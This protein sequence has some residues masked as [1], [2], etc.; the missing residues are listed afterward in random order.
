MEY[1]S[2]VLTNTVEPFVFD[3][4]TGSAD[5]TCR[6]YFVMEHKG[7]SYYAIDL[8]K[9]DIKK[10]EKIIKSCEECE[11]DTWQAQEDFFD[12][13]K[14]SEILMYIE[15]DG[16]VVGFN[17]VSLLFYGEYCI[18]SI[19]EAMVRKKYQGKNLARNV[20]ILTIRWFLANSSKAKQVKKIC[21]LSISANPKVV[22]NYYKNKYITNVFDNSFNASQGLAN[23]L[24]EYMK[25]NS[26]SLVHEDY[27]FCIKNLFPGSN[28]FD[29]GD[30][31]FQ[32]CDEVKKR[33]PAD[34]D[35]IDRGDAFAWLVVVSAPSF[36]LVNFILMH[37]I[38]GPRFWFNRK[39][40][41]F[42]KKTSDFT[43]AVVKPE[44]VEKRLKDRRV[45]NV[46]LLILGFPDRRIS[47]RRSAR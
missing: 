9:T 20:V 16:T 40:G 18:Y 24:R 25:K 34:F 37:V 14:R 42:R 36:W 2:Q 33:M 44:F 10:V 43:K 1:S 46:D 7:F 35:H 17:L 3:V 39:V 38:Y 23:L 15:K 31:R 27:P 41:L 4:L 30:K 13:I 28:C 22:N 5:I 32:F 19:D 47:D 29:P 21:P 45:A 11:A 12:Y 8:T 26:L 6:D